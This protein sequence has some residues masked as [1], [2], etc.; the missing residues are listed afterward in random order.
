MLQQINKRPKALKGL[1][2][3][4]VAKDTEYMYTRFE[5]YIRENDLYIK[6]QGK[7]LPLVW[8]E[9]VNFKDYTYLDIVKQFDGGR[10]FEDGLLK[11]WDTYGLDSG[12]KVGTLKRL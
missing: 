1:K 5:F 6:M 7:Y 11:V 3:D 9:V 4:I 2:P 8:F 12:Y 10:H